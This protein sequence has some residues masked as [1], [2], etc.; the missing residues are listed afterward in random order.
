MPEPPLTL[1]ALQAWPLERII[2]YCLGYLGSRGWP[3]LAARAGFRPL[4]DIAPCQ[5]EVVMVVVAEVMNL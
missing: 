2:M 1:S 4:G 5:C 3:G